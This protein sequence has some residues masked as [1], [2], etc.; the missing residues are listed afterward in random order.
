MRILIFISKFLKQVEKRT[1]TFDEIKGV[2]PLIT[3]A[4]AYD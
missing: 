2:A 3:A 1:V 4:K